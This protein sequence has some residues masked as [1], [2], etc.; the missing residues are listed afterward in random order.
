VSGVMVTLPPGRDLALPSSCACCGDPG[1]HFVIAPRGS[2]AESSFLPVP[3]CARCHPH[4]ARTSTRLRNI[5][6]AAVL[7]G[8]VVA[9]IA[10]LVLPLSLPALIACS[11][12]LGA[13]AA[14]G[15][16][17]MAV[18]RNAR[19]KGCTARGAPVV[20]TSLTEEGATF[21][22]SREGWAQELS[23]LSAGRMGPAVK[24]DH[25][26]RALSVLAVAVLPAIGAAALAGRFTHSPV[27][28]DNGH[29]TAIDVYAD[30]ARAGTFGPTHDEVPSRLW[31]RTGTHRLA[32]AQAG[33]RP[34]PGKEAAGSFHWA[35]GLYNPGAAACHW[36]EVHYYGSM[37]GDPGGP[38]PEGEVIDQGFDQ[39]F[40]EPPKKIEVSKRDTGGRRTALYRNTLCTELRRHGCPADVIGAYTRCQT[41]AMGPDDARACLDAAASACGLK[42]E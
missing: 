5:L 13:L 14:T 2:V 11:A 39:W 19:K 20:E 10:V 42:E 22:C 35:G 28:V 38:M 32:F 4:A 36:R 3:V 25:R 15:A 31:L 7:V 21:H 6:G 34:E 26:L 12:I 30:G 29:A 33:G 18:S 40:R 8:P 23:E 37:M 9:G 1:Q 27:Y 41:T 16:A 24:P 17:R